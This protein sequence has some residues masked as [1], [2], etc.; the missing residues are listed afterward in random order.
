MGRMQG[1]KGTGHCLPA[2]LSKGTN[3][4]PVVKQDGWTDEGP[5]EDPTL[6]S[7]QQQFGQCLGNAEQASSAAEVTARFS[8]TSNCP[9]SGLG[10]NLTVLPRRPMLGSRAGTHT[11]GAPVATGR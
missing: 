10:W 8:V 1:M 11:L 7:K 4:E 9:E 5:G 6:R 3:G 2:F